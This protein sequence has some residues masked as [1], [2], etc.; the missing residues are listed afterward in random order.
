MDNSDKETF[1]NILQDK[2]NNNLKAVNE[3]LVKYL[4][5]VEKKKEANKSAYQKHKDNEEFKQ[6]RQIM[7]SN[8]TMNINKNY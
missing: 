1:R 8:T 7:I 3:V 4:E 2:Y 5:I 6:K